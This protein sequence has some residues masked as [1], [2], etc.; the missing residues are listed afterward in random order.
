[1]L[2]PFPT[3]DVPVMEIAPL[4]EVIAAR[5]LTPFPVESGPSIPPASVIGPLTVQGARGQLDAAGRADGQ[6]RRVGEARLV[7]LD[8]LGQGT[9]AERDVEAAQ[10]SVRSAVEEVDRVIVPASIILMVV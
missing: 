1:M 3:L 9:L 5:I 4:V 10:V 7:D 8:S 2:M 6:S